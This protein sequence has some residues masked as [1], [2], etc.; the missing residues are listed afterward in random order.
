MRVAAE[1]KD[2]H[3][4]GVTALACTWDNNGVVSGGL[5]GQVRVWKYTH[6]SRFDPIRLMAV[7]KEHRSSVTDIKINRNNDECVSTSEDGS[8]VI[9]DLM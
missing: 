1:M 7:M 4:M 3:C 8:C 5:D 6:G 9:W 2:A